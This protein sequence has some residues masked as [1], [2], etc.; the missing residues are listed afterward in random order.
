LARC[1]GADER[2]VKPSP[3]ENAQITR[4]LFNRLYHD[5]TLNVGNDMLGAVGHSSY[6]QSK[7]LDAVTQTEAPE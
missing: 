5:R 4:Y 7:S 2:D 1:F 3:V 6:R